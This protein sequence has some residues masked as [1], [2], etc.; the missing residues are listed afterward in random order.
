[1]LDMEGR[2]ALHAGWSCKECVSKV[3]NKPGKGWYARP[4]AEAG[5]RSC[6]GSQLLSDTDHPQ[7]CRVGDSACRLELSG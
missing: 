5:A 4:S 1:M 7:H 2:P 3:N 6:I